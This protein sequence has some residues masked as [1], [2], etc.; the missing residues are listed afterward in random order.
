MREVLVFAGLEVAEQRKH[1]IAV[2]IRKS[3]HATPAIFDRGSDFCSLHTVAHADERR[4]R[5]RG[6]GAI[7]S[8]T[9]SA[10]GQIDVPRAVG[11]GIFRKGASPGHVVRIDVDDSRLR[12][13]RR[14]TPF[15]AAV[16]TRKDYRVFADAKGDELPVITKGLELFERPAVRF[17]RPVGQ[18][19]CAQSLPGKGR[20]PCRK[21]LFRGGLLAPK[22]AGRIFPILDREKRSSI[23][24]V[25][26][27]EESLFGG[28]RDRVDVLA[29]A[30][31][32]Q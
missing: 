23:G 2:Q 1:L 31:D 22:I 7:F 26:K 30:P 10:L 29:A 24:A 16:K 11:T 28:L 21:R 12:I 14:A 8:V 13:D 3:G 4:D 32:R 5:G 17:W 27:I 25:E 15:R 9:D 6:T 19:V 18:K 20:G